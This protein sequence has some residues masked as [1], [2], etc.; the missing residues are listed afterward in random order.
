M[1]EI[2]L[3]GIIKNIQ[4]SHTINN[5]DFYK[6][7]L[8]VARKN[9]IE[10][11]I[12]LKFKQFSNPYNENEE[13]QLVGNV[14]TYN[15]KVDQK[16]KVDLF[17]FTY[18]DKPESD[19]EENN[20]IKI[21]GFICKKTDIKKTNC[22]K[23]VLDFILANHLENNGQILNAYLP[24]VAWGKIAKEMNNL[25]ISSKI[26]I[27]GSLQSREYKKFLPNGDYELRICNEI[28]VKDFKIENE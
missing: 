2:K 11:L 19:L 5:V 20:D 14:R 7:D 26:T 10:D 13:I 6:A 25:K 4:Y 28:L 1:N 9:G 8:I 3:K 24:C 18:F 22:G 12:S 16:N 17:V 21:D 27:G 15:H 23:D